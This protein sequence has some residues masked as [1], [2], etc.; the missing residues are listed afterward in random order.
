[1]LIFS[2]MILSNLSDQLITRH[3][4]QLISSKDGLN[5]MIW[6]WG[7]L[8]LLSTILFPLLS[9]LLCS[10][11]I[12]NSNKAL[13]AFVSENMEL[14][15]IETLRSWGKAF[16]WTFVFVI[17]GIQRFI[18]YT[19]TP[20]VV[21]FSKKYKAGEVDALD[22]STVITKKYWKPVNLW[23]T[24]YFVVIPVVFYMLFEEYRLFSMY[25]VAATGLVFLKT[26]V[27]YSFNFTMLKILIKYLNETEFVPETAIEV[28]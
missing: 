15:L 2:A 28:H 25:P 27:E 21:F 3:V 19:L 11:C 7:A 16:M 20:Y 12:I 17:P 14:S 13:K 8:S 5:G 24:V 18:H 9:A 1:M 4:E 26:V 23:I 6:L 22:Y 10:Y